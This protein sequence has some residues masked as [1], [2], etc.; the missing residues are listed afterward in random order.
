MK[1]ELKSPYYKFN[2]ALIGTTYKKRMAPSTESVAKAI[3]IFTLVFLATVFGL[4]AIGVFIYV[5]AMMASHKA[6][7]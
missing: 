3:C 6:N 7:I 1:R 5:T 2:P 4:L